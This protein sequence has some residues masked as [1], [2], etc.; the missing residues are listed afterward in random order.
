[1]GINIRQ[2]ET[3]FLAKI[4]DTKDEK[5]A[6]VSVAVAQANVANFYAHS[7]RCLARAG[8]EDQFIAQPRL[9]GQS[10]G[11]DAGQAEPSIYEFSVT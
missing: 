3:S 8:K 2:R 7:S 9:F 6:M 4:A 10:P 11:A 1:M 5:L